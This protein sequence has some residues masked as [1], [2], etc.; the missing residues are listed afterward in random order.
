MVPHPCLD[1]STLLRMDGGARVEAGRPP[2]KLVQCN[3]GERRHWVPGLG[4]R[5]WKESD[6][7]IFADHLDMERERK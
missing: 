2:G 3:P 4:R 1:R 6:F 7:D 5:K